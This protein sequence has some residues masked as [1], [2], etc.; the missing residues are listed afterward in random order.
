MG[1]SEA[2]SD[3]R[4]GSLSLLSF[5]HLRHSNPILPGVA[6]DAGPL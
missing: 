5:L 6:T 4:S 3:I 1:V 2:S